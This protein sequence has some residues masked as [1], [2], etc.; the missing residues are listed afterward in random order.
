MNEFGNR[1]SADA[2]WKWFFTTHPAPAPVL[3]QVADMS[4]TTTWT[5]AS[6]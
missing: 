6:R 4:M 1:V 5:S 2:I 3:Q